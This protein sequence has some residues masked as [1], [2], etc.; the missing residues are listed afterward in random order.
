MYL[1]VQNFFTK[2]NIASSDQ[3]VESSSRAVD[4]GRKWGTVGLIP[5][6]S[7]S[8]PLLTQSVGLLKSNTITQVIL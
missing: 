3:D 1:E 6:P 8:S 7:A 2:I 5:K 4:L